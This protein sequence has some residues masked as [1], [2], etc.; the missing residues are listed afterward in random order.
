MHA[1][2]LP[3]VVG[4]LLAMGVLGPS[5]AADEADP[6]LRADLEALSRRSIYFG[7]QSVGMNLVEGIRD[8][9]AQEGVPLRIVEVQGAA[10]GAPGTFA[11]GF[12]AENGNP[13]LKLQSFERALGTGPAPVD[14]AFLKFCFVDVVDRTDAKALFEHYQATLR[15]LQAKHARTTFVH[16]TVP[17]TSVQAGWKAAVKSL[18]GRA[19][20]GYLENARREEFNALLRAAYQGHEPLFDLARVESTAPDGGLATAVVNGRPVPALV[21]SYTDDGGHLSGVGRR[22]V[23]RELIRFLAAVPPRGARGGADVTAR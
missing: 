1:L 8:L 5:A 22:R 14:V 10:A 9:A 13:R 4:G 21:P 2:A 18:L 23:A 16:V 6:A 20:Y 12:L 19:P 7:H 15:G 11:H 3:Q 17:L